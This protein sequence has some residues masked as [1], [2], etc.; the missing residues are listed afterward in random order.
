M[1]VISMQVTFR[2]MRLKRL[3]K[4]KRGERRN[5][6]RRLRSGQKGENQEWAG[7]WKAL[8]KEGV[9]K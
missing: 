1:G 8:F 9:S 6:R 5:Q 2:V 7:S 4:E 3:C